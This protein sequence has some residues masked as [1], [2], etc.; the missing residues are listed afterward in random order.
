MYLR[1]SGDMDG[2]WGS[3]LQTLEML[4]SRQEEVVPPFAKREGRC[5]GFPRPPQLRGL[6]RRLAGLGVGL[7][8]RV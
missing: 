6:A 2:D 7:C 3:A 5:V 1:G 4:P 8:A